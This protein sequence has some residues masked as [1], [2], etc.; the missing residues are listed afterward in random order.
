[1]IRQ[2]HAHTHTH[3]LCIHVCACI[4]VGMCLCMYVRVTCVCV[5][6][7]VCLYEC[8][9]QIHFLINVGTYRDIIMNKCIYIMKG[10]R[11]IVFV[12]IAISA[13]FRPIYPPAYF[14]CLLNSGTYTELRTTSFIES[15]EVA[16]SDSPAGHIA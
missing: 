2:K 8:K 15:T 4:P 14:R 1:M 10:F 6:V 5:Y 13:T 11:T 12:F 16:C 3:T 9:H 7:C